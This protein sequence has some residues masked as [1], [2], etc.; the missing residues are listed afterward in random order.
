MTF[1]E[2]FPKKQMLLIKLICKHAT[3]AYDMAV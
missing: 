3:E 1:A 2:K